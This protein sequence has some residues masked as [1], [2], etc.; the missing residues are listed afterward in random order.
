[1][2]DQIKR[3]RMFFMEAEKGVRELDKDSRW[4]VGSLSLFIRFLLC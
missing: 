4:P 2:R 1:M 3:A